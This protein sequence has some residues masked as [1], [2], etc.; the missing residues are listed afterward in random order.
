[1]KRYII[2]QTAR[3]A[4]KA[5]ALHLPWLG[6]VIAERDELRQQV[7]GVI[8]ERDELRQPTSLCAELPEDTSQNGLAGSSAKRLDLSEFIGFGSLVFDIGAFEGVKTLEYLKLGASVV[9]FE[10]NRETVKVLQEKFKNNPHVRIEMRGLSDQEGVRLFYAS[11]VRAQ[12][13]FSESLKK[14]HWFSRDQWS[15]IPY[16][17]EITTIM[18]MVKRYGLPDFVKIDVEGLEASVLRGMGDARPQSLSFEFYPAFPEKYGE[19]IHILQ[20][21]G[22]SKFNYIINGIIPNQES[23]EFRFDGWV[24]QEVLLSGLSE[25]PRRAGMDWGDVYATLL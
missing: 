5:V 6:G 14:S 23:A 13:T 9:C 8:A 1:M 24:D 16:E 2:R 11:T 15:P 20:D 25:E 22:Y 21:L 10:P 17:V 4:M 19:C 7:G 18:Q 3:K 12:S